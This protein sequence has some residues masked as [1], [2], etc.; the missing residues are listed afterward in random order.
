MLSIEKDTSAHQTLQLRSFFRLF[1]RNEVPPDYYRFARGEIDLQQLY[2]LHP[3]QAKKAA[4]E[5]WCVE[6]GASSVADVRVRI[7]RALGSSEPWVLLGGPPCQPFSLAG[8]SRNVRD[9]RYSEGKE[10]R[11]Q[12]YIEYLQIIADF[13]PSV[14]VMENVR[15]LLTAKY[16][17]VRMFDKIVDD[18]CDP[19]TAIDRIPGRTRI[20]QH[21]SHGYR[22]FPLTAVSHAEESADGYIHNYIVK[23]EMHGVPQ[24]RHRLI[25]VGV[26]DDISGR[27][28]SLAS[29]EKVEAKKVF[30]GLPRLRSGL[31]KSDESTAWLASVRAAG[32]SG[33]IKQ[34]KKSD[35]KVGQRVEDSIHRLSDH[36][37]GRGKPFMSEKIGVSHAPEWYLDSKLGGVCN[38]QSR[39][40]MVSDLHRYL[41][42]ACF[43]EV[44][45]RSPKIADFPKKLLPD[46]GSV[47]RALNGSHFA[48]RFRVQLPNRPSTTVVSHI[49]KDGHYY[50][51]PD[52]GQCRSLTVREAARLQSFPDNYLFL[53][54]RT[55]QYT[56]VGNAVPPF[57]AAQ[58]ADIVYDLLAKSEKTSV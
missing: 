47:W 32:S 54:N 16:E 21:R 2:A 53:G 10:T 25:I 57:L 46:H 35:E 11:H 37:G 45:G 29:R 14:F 6:L 39:G 58:I 42:A 19:A 51:H 44:H 50:I 12:L 20:Q 41:F 55:Q 7:E 28:A 22:L 4:D 31:S 49:A 23:S 52:P 43:A 27:P 40:H 5:A 38:H 56:Q 24:A 17:G 48:D 18:L 33:W 15:G 13:W 36:A 1:P 30:F 8:R 26:R 3:E 34:L 9:T